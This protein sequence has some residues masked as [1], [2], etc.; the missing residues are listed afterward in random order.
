MANYKSAS[1]QLE[2]SWWL[3]NNTTTGAM[4]ITT[5]CVINQVIYFLTKLFHLSYKS[6]NV[7]SEKIMFLWNFC[8]L[9]PVLFYD[10]NTSINDSLW[11]FRVFSTN[12]FLEAGFIFQ[13]GIIVFQMGELKKNQRMGGTPKYPSPHYGKPCCNTYWK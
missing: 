10:W 5:N 3:Q 2:N 11:F 1:G 7:R 8:H 4:S 13:C 12:Y 6:L 9:F